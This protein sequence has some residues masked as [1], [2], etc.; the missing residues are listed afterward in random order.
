ML[1]YDHD[2]ALE[3][4]RAIADDAGDLGLDGLVG[5]ALEIEGL[6]RAQDRQSEA[7]A[8]LSKA[9]ELAVAR[10]EDAAAGS[11]A[12]EL[13]R[14]LAN[15]RRFDE[16]GDWLRHAEAAR[17]RAPPSPVAEAEHAAAQ[18]WVLHEHTTSGD[19][20]PACERAASLARAEGVS[21]RLRRSSARLLAQVY[22]EAGRF[23][24]AEA[25]LRAELDRNSHELGKTHPE[26]R[27]LLG[28]LSA[29]A[30][31]Q[32]HAED[33]ISLQREFIAIT[34]AAAPD[35]VYVLSKHYL[36]L[37]AYLAWMGEYEEA[38]MAMARS[39]TLLAA[40]VDADPDDLEI[41]RCRARMQQA[42]IWIEQGKTERALEQLRDVQRIEHR[43]LPED[44]A[45]VL[46][47]ALALGA[48]L[49]H[50]DQP[51][52]AEVELVKAL[53]F[54]RDHG[55]PRLAEVLVHYAWA[56]E[57]QG[58]ILEAAEHHHEAIVAA[59]MTSPV[60]VYAMGRLVALAVRSGDTESAHQWLEHAS[61]LALTDEL[62]EGSPTAALDFGRA[63]LLEARGDRAGAEASARR[64]Q[65]ILVESDP[66]TFEIMLLR[67]VTAWQAA[68]DRDRGR[69]PGR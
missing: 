57:E 51:A 21:P 19:W 26:T 67:Q 1:A 68:R 13:A 59:G 46:S 6:V 7:I 36:S 23:V 14:A 42:L 24:E 10:G 39:L 15:A 27:I 2:A 8:S 45:Q 41:E 40:R 49:L 55:H 44:N 16:A 9:Y 53:P 33:A 3:L 22:G 34:E 61:S 52:A 43:L 60:G 12:R 5:D 58:R 66:A 64:A 20:L 32:L 18:C 56:L 65:E 28:D 63:L 4:A 25:I 29:V 17:L 50:S 35:D 37:A 30:A 47:T 62:I 54:L 69:G 48:A 38:D 31:L 11:R